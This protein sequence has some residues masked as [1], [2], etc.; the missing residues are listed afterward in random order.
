VEETDGY[1]NEHFITLHDLLRDLTLMQSSNDPGQWERLNIDLRGKNQLPNWW[2]KRKEKSFI[3]RLVT[4]S[5]EKKRPSE[6]SKMELMELP[7]AEVLVLNFWSK[8]YALPKFVGKMESLKALIVT[9]YKSFPA[10]V[11]NFNLL[12]P[13]KNL[14]RIRLDHISIP[15]LNLVP[16]ENLQKI[17]FYMCSIGKAFS[18]CPTKISELFP[19]I[20]EMNVDFCNDLVELP[21]EICDIEPLEK[22]TISHC[23]KL[24][25]LPEDIGKLENLEELRLRCCI[26]LVVLPDS[27]SKLSNLTFL[28]L[29]N[30]ISI[31]SLPED[32]G[33]LHKLSKLNMT[34]CSRLPKL[35]WSVSNLTRLEDLICDEE[36]QEL[37]EPFL[38]PYLLKTVV[39]L[40]EEDINLNWLPLSKNIA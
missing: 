24:R 36:T 29:S 26:S 23:T 21:A 32:I 2:D 7:E 40:A 27:I 31:E 10:E 17:S 15:S 20:T 22:L 11:K 9:S 18:N 16:L 12:C 3:A 33:G 25:V 5:S 28:D 19:N 14:R 4:I 34:H 1:Y 35:P 6:L 8:D 37:W 39:K 38:Q 30:C 13:L